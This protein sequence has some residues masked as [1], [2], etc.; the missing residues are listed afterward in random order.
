[1]LIT[2]ACDYSK[3]QVHEMS[4]LLLNFALLEYYLV[5]NLTIVGGLFDNAVS[6]NYPG[7][8]PLWDILL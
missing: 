6:E 2:I 7:I 5:E 3:N 8:I 4:I 1:M